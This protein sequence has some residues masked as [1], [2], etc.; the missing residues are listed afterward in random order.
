M[1]SPYVTGHLT[2][3]VSKVTIEP[4]SDGWAYIRLY[5]K[6]GFDFHKHRVCL[7]IAI[8]DND[9]KMRELFTGLEIDEETILVEYIDDITDPIE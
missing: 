1:S 6:T 7:N 9:N 2:F 8:T 5:Q 3:D 4:Q